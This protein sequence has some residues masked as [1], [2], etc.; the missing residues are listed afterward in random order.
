M[1][2]FLHINQLKVTALVLTCDNHGMAAASLN[3]ISTSKGW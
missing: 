1:L 2:C 3:T